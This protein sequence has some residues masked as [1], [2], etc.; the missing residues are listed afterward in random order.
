[1]RTAVIDALGK[2][3]VISS[4]MRWAARQYRD[5]S[6][7]NIKSG[8]LA[9]K[10][11][12]RHKRFVN[13]YWVSIYELPLQHAIWNNLSEGDV[14]YDLGANGG[15]F[16][17]L[18][19]IRVGPTGY[20]YAF[21]PDKENSAT[22]P[23]QFDL[24][25][26]TWAEVVELA[27]SD[28]AGQAAFKCGECSTSRLVE[29]PTDCTSLVQ[30]VTLD[31]FSLT[32]RAPSLVKIDV[33]GIEAAVLRGSSNVLGTLRPKLLI[34]LH[35]ERN[36]TECARILKTHGYTITALSES[37]MP[38]GKEMPHHILAQYGKIEGVRG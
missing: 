3:P 24:N 13:G 4:V 23:D 14:F 8:L 33:E 20:V 12:K 2:I 5:G 34:E 17:L 36:C 30:T 35:D 22:I 9:G 1:M 6:V 18:A 38:N 10:K 32:H 27:V 16:S 37:P 19:A 15:F 21:E 25:G 11:W 7:T 31:E 29:S 28:K 26:V